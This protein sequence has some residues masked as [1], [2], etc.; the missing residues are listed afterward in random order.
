MK[1]KYQ[2]LKPPEME[3]LV[4]DFSNYP[5]IKSIKLSLED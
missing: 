5:N 2:K 3:R 1:R 4:V